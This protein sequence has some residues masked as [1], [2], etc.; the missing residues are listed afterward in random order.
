M[1]AATPPGESPRPALATLAESLLELN[2]TAMARILEIYG[3]ADVGVETKSDDS[4]VTAA[5]HAADR[6]LTDGLLALTPDVPVVSEERPPPPELLE[7]VAPPR[8]WLVDP[9]D[10]TREFIDRNGEFT[11]N[12]ALVEDGR[13]VLGL[14]G[15]PVTGEVFL[16]IQG[17]GAFVVAG[18]PGAWQRR[19]IAVRPLQQ[20]LRLLA[21]RRVGGEATARFLARCEERFDAV[22]LIQAGSALKLCRVAEGAADAY[23]RPGPTCWWDTAAAQAVVEAAGGEVWRW[24]SREPMRYRPQPGTFDPLNP[25][26]LVV[27]DTS[28]DW[29][30]LMGASG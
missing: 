26:F 20:T 2:A 29:V 15:L 17:E 12:V 11:T 8:F 4:P 23:A 10:G 3:R 21:S 13:P 9:L 25:H 14:V 7:G 19:P 22:T 27:A 24:G 28:V 6:V 16:G 18:E 1:S 30:Q 5:D